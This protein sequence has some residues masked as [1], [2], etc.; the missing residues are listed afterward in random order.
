[1]GALVGCFA[2][3]PLQEP[4]GEILELFAE[5]DLIC[6]GETHLSRSDA[7]LRKALIKHPG[8]AQMVDVIVVEF[9]N[10]IHQDLLDRRLLAGEALSEEESRRVRLDAGLGEIWQSDLYAE[11]FKIVAQ[12]NAQRAPGERIRIVGAALP[13]DWGVVSEPENLRGTPD[14]T[15]YFAAVLRQEILSPGLKGLAVFGTGHCE[16]APPSAFSLLAEEHPERVRAIFGFETSGGGIAGKR[17]FGL[18]DAPRLLKIRGTSM[19]SLPSGTMLFEGHDFAGR[20]LGDVVDAIVDYGAY[21][22]GPESPPNLE[23]ALRREL[24]RR[25]RLW[26]SYLRLVSEETS[27]AS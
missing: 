7:A 8:F 4:A 20:A 25:A 22:E 14:R 16:R 27:P 13:I 24:E 1:M 19:A 6:L 17:V 23:P 21:F 15:E 9:A 12:V 26:D 18:S 11:F 3:E 2:P 5:A 10:P